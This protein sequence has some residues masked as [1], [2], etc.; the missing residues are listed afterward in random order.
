MKHRY[1]IKPADA[2]DLWD[3]WDTVQDAPVFGADALPKGR[4]RDVARQL[5][6]AYRRLYPR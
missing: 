5:N 2:P 4:A 6:A 1:V 3:V